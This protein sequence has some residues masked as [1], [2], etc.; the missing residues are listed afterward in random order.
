MFQSLSA[1]EAQM[2]KILVDF[3]NHNSYPD[4]TNQDAAY[5]FYLC[6]NKGYISNVFTLQNANRDYLFQKSG[7]DHITEDGLKFIRDTSFLRRFVYGIFAILRGT[8]GFVLGVATTVI[9]AYIIW[10]NGWI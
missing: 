3:K 6:C 4:V 10:L 2:R 5:A 7:N 8:L 9:S 1:L